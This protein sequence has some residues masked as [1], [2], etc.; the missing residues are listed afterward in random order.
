M[1]AGNH[2]KIRD[3]SADA[4]DIFHEVKLDTK[5]GYFAEEYA[6]FYLAGLL[7]NKERKNL[8]ELVVEDGKF[9]TCPAIEEGTIHQAIAQLE[10]MYTELKGSILPFLST[11]FPS[12]E[13]INF[14][15]CFAGFDGHDIE[16]KMPGTSFGTISLSDAYHEDGPCHPADYYFTFKPIV[17]IS[18]SSINQN[19]T[20]YYT[21]VDSKLD[22]A[23]PEISKPI[24]DAL[25]KKGAVE[26]TIIWLEVKSIGKF[27]METVRCKNR[28]IIEIDFSS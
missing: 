24:F 14:V 16:I 26:S 27:V 2:T 9:H 28:K 3:I 10:F 15:S 4:D 20:K 5:Y 17:F 25:T 1:A 13:R 22:G 7:R 11:Y 23:T 8:R 21:S 18:V 6:G 19:T 12:L